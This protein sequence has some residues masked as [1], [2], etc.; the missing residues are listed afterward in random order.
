[1]TKK[2]FKSSFIF[3]IGDILNKAVPFLLLPIL[4]KY[5]SPQDYGLIASFMI[6]IPAFGILLGFGTESSIFSNYFR[7]NKDHLKI[8]IANVLYLVIFSFVLLISMFFIFIDQNQ[9]FLGFNRI[10]L[11]LALLLALA[12]LITTMNLRLW[13]AEEKALKYSIYQI[14]QTFV[15]VILS[16][17]LVI[18]FNMKWEGYLIGYSINIFLFSIFS[19]ILIFRRGYLKFNFNIEYIKDALKFGLPLVPNAA[20]NWL[21]SGSDRIVIISVL[22]SS[23]AGIY[24][25]ALQFAMVIVIIATGFN[26]TWS[27]F[28]FK[29]L[30]LKPTYNE[31]VKLVKYIYLY[32]IIIFVFAVLYSKTLYYLIP[33]LIDERFIESRNYI[34][35]L[36][37]AFAF[38]GM[39]FMVTSFIF[40]EKK[41]GRLSI[42]TLL[43]SSLYF[44]LLIIMIFLNGITGVVQAILI[45]Y[46][47]IFIVTWYLS[48]KIYPMPWFSFQEKNFLDNIK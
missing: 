25:V 10:W 36:S 46:I 2:L 13:I 45:L 41:T 48:N 27:S 26:K 15:S 43:T 47:I 40:Y 22:G 11:F 38:Q 33:L 7:M 3:I 17:I 42:V 31:K 44:I 14:S 23:F 28:L 5:L 29:K 37:L 34:L 21:K 39:Y 32:F 24:S 16:L 1:L 9:F 20:A 30:S 19:L 35:Y 18:K 4:T 6:L 8:F 12:Q